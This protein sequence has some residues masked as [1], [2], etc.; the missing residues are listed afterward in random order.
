VDVVFIGPNDLSKSM[1]M[2]PIFDSDHPQYV[3][4]V[5]HILETARKHGVAPGIH[6]VDVDS[7]KRRLA[8]G[9]QF[10]AVASEAGMMVGKA[11]EIAR[12]L[13]VGGKREVV[14]Y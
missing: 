6:V 11:T 10:V 12:Q 1:G 3:A 13:G 9:F 2:V 7:A 14:R 8:E 5:R 4:A